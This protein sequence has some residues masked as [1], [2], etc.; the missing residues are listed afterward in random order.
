[1]K[2]SHAILLPVATFLLMTLFQGGCTRGASDTER[3]FFENVKRLCGQSLEG[4]TVFPDDKEHPLVGRK[5][6]MRVEECSDTEIRIPFEVGEDRSRTWILTLG[7][8]GL[9]FKHDHRHPDGTPD[10]ITMYGGW[11]AAGGTAYR[12]EF[13]ADSTTAELL[14]EAAT[15]VWMIATTSR[16]IGRCSGCR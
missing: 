7:E 8:R 11:S 2:H 6:V 1:V 12:Q 13:P 14:P 9:L 4:T 5:L 10:S 16:G 3:A 15:N